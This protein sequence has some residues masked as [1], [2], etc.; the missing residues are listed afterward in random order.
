MTKRSGVAVRYQA[1]GQ[2]APWP[3]QPRLVASYDAEGAPPKPLTLLVNV[4]SD[5]VG[6]ESGLHSYY[7]DTVTQAQGYRTVRRTLELNAGL[8]PFSGNAAG[9]AMVITYG[10]GATER[11]IVCDLKSGSYVLP[12]CESAR[13][14]AIFWQPSPVDWGFTVTGAFVEGSFAA[15]SRF[16]HSYMDLAAINT[17]SSSIDGLHSFD[18]TVPDGARWIQVWQSLGMATEQS[19]V[20]VY[21]D[22]GARVDYDYIA[23]SAPLDPIELPTARDGEVTV[24]HLS[25]DGRRVCVRF[26]LEP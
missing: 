14:E 4:L 5:N 21:L 12:P 6:D 10:T 18:L 17:Q 20:R 9:G 1:T 8:S 22:R 23:G 2:P 11:R 26:Y 15:P 24:M 3:Q 19:N 7:V 25:Q 13:M 16:T